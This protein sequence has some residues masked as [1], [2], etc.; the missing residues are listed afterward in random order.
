MQLL[1]FFCLIS[2]LNAHVWNSDGS[3]RIVSQFIEMFAKTLSS[4]NRNAICNLFDDQYVFV[5][6]TRQLNKELATHVLTHL[7]AGTQFSFQ[8]VKSCYKH[9][10]VIEFS[11]NVQGLGAPFQAQ[12]LLVLGRG[13]L[14]LTYG[15]MTVCQQV[16]VAPVAPIAPPAIVDNSQVIVVTFLK[17]LEGVIYQKDIQRFMQ[18]VAD[19]FIWQDCSAK[20]DRTQTIISLPNG[21]CQTSKL[22]SYKVVDSSCIEY[23]VITKGV[24]GTA[25]KVQFTLHLNQ[26]GGQLTGAKT[27]ECS[28]AQNVYNNGNNN[29]NNQ[30]ALQQ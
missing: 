11:A 2:V 18:L 29:N 30:Y 10:N 23:T 12:F 24:Q 14:K 3:D 21:A 13:T 16:P 7:P 22:L 6:C 27:L 25:V 26:N 8:L 28:M 9:Q 1:V 4:H 15:T 19:G 20:Y 17:Q 5:G